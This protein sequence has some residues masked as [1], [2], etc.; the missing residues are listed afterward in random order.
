M[1]IILLGATGNTGLQL[2]EQACKRGH[3][4]LIRFRFTYSSQIINI[5]IDLRRHSTCTQSF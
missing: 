3:G 1:K 4:L 2:A 5:F